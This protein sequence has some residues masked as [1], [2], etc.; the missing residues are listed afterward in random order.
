MVL[1]GL[2]TNLLGQ[3]ALAQLGGVEMRGDQMV[4]R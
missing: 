2:Q 1:E 3:S 4:L